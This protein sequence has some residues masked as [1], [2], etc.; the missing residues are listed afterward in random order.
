MKKK[1]KTIIVTGGS[2]G[3]G[4]SISTR[5]AEAGYDLIITWRTSERIAKETQQAIQCVGT[6]CSLMRVDLERA[7]LEQVF[8]GIDK[9]AT[10]ALYG[11]VN[12]AAHVGARRPSNSISSADW[13]TTFEVNLF[14]VA[15]LCKQVFSYM[16]YGNGG[17]GGVIVNISSQVGQYG[18]N[19]ILP[20]AASKSALNLLTVCLAREYGP[21]GVRV[22]AVSPG[23][24]DTKDEEGRALTP[25]EKLTEIPL[26]RL[27]QP[28][29]I[30]EAVLWLMSPS[31]SFVSGTVLPVHGAR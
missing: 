14:S 26:R 18:G 7:D 5:L 25:T 28:S 1:N 13:R 8:E 27:G 17:A 6:T 4:R 21:S 3:I 12:N 20:Y 16:S 19:G 30:A 24:I 9:R 31:S 29:D 22:N 10:S 2:R 15:E 11:L 23:I